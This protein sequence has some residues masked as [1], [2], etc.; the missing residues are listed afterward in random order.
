[1][2]LV[3]EGA[4]NEGG[5]LV[6]AATDMDTELRATLPAR[7]ERDGEFTVPVRTLHDIARKL[8]EGSQIELEAAGDKNTHA[9]MAVR[10][11]RSLFRRRSGVA[12]GLGRL[13]LSE[14]PAHFAREV[15]G[16]FFDFDTGR[17]DA[18]APPEH[19][20]CPLDKLMIRHFPS[21]ARTKHPA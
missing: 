2:L 9:E 5:R 18:D 14:R 12:D 10:A 3:A 8:R 20:Q 7:V 11:G 4:G 15:D 1:M 19:M 13:V 21:N 17:R 6:L 16:A